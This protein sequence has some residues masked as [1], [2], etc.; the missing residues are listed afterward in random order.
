MSDRASEA[1]AEGFLPGEP[2]TYDAISKRRNIPLSTLHHRAQGRRSREQK[3]Q[4]Q[5]YLTPSEEKALEKFLILM[6]DLG[7]PVRIKFV[8]SLAFSIARQRSTTGKAIKPPGK[9]WA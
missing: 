4:S 8:P 7:N 3:A 9:N 2:R 1:L 6:S 5:Q